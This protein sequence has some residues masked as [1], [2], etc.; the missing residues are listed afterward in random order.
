MGSAERVH[1]GLPLSVNRRPIMKNSNGVPAASKAKKT[2]KSAPKGLGSTSQRARAK[3]TATNRAIATE[4]APAVAIALLDKSEQASNA[5]APA[6]EC[7]VAGAA[8]SE[9]VGKVRV[10]LMFETGAVLPVEMSVAAGAALAKGLTE[11][12]PK[13]R[14][15][16]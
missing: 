14:S 3:R 2:P 7:L 11:E 6:L 15:K 8:P 12:L 5:P 10:Q 9:R 13:K 1:L 16:K 4:L